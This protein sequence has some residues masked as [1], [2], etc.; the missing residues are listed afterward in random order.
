M[1]NTSSH[2]NLLLEARR[3]VM[4]CAHR[5]AS[6]SSAPSRMQFSAET[7]SWSLLS[8]GMKPSCPYKGQT[9]FS[10]PSLRCSSWIPSSLLAGKISPSMTHV[11]PAFQWLREISDTLSDLLVPVIFWNSVVMKPLH[12]NTHTFLLVLDTGVKRYV[13]LHIQIRIKWGLSL[14]H[15][16]YLTHW[17]WY[18]AK[19]PGPHSTWELGTQWGTK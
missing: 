12:A 4:S 2:G 10:S 13:D 6:L 7:S 3:M 11:P 9:L 1:T 16:G 5:G 17:R 14:W 8:S 18:W 19:C 15:G